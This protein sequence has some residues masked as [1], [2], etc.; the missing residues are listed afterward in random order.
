MYPYL[1]FKIVLIS[2]LFWLYVFLKKKGQRRELLLMGLVFAVLGPI[3]EWWYT[4]DYWHPNYIGHWPWIEDIIFGFTVGGL[5]SVLYESLFS[6]KVKE[7]KSYTGHPALF[8]SIVLVSTFG[9]GLLAPFVNSIY[10]AIITFVICWW[11]ILLV[12]PDLLISSL[13]S[14]LLLTIL[15][16]VGYEV[17]FYFYPGLVQSWWDLKNI[18]GILVLKIPLEEYMWF[19]TMG[20]LAGP[21]YEFLRGL[22]F[23]KING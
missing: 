15:M 8:A 21:L 16:F 14:A 5:A 18:S 12:R 4:K 11:I 7:I 3:Q 6:R 17:I 10:A 22:G 1:Y 20:L 19:W 23:K 2:C 9:I 13:Y